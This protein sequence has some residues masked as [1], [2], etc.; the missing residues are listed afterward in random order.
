MAKFGFDYDDVDVVGVD[1][2]EGFDYDGMWDEMLSDQD[3]AHA[4]LPAGWDGGFDPSV[5]DP[6]QDDAYYDWFEDHGPQ[7][8]PQFYG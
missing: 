7:I 5:K 2:V 6:V 8:D 1:E 4:H 3:E